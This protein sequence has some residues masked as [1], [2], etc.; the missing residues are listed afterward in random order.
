[1][2]QVDWKKLPEEVRDFIWNKSM[3]VNDAIYDKYNLDYDQMESVYELEDKVFLKIVPPLNLPNEL[4]NIPGM[5]DKDVRLLALDIAYKLLWPLQYYLG[6]ID[7]LIL[8]LGGKV[9][10]PQSLPKKVDQSES[11]TQLATVA[12]MMSKNIDFKSLL[13]SGNKIIDKDGRKVSPTVE[14]WLADYIHFLGAGQHSSLQRAQ[15]LAKNPNALALSDNDRESLRYFL[16]SYD[17][18]VKVNFDL[19]GHIIKV[20]EIKEAELQVEGQ[21]SQTEALKQLQEKLQELD[22]SLLGDEFILSEANG[23]LIKLRDVLWQAIGLQDQDKVISCLR[24]LISKRLLDRMLLEDKRYKNILKRFI[25][26]RYGSGIHIDNTIDKLLV[27]RLF[28]EMLF[29]TKLHLA[30]DALLVVLYLTNILPGDSQ[31]VYFDTNDN[32][33]K[34]LELQ[35]SRNSLVWI[36]K[37]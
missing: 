18:Q 11:T 22:Q 20:T 10:S 7:K 16:I 17:D 24:V 30:E 36:D 21:I 13:L 3:E 5:Q 8:R 12:E 28:F 1:M 32:Q 27:R 26:L 9:P 35:V 23:D 4:E 34:W 25:D 2:K 15:Y 31:L 6:E 37:V 19:A 14:N 29:V 33:L